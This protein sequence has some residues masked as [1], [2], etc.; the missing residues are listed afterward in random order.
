MPFVTDNIKIRNSDDQYMDLNPSSIDLE[1]IKSDIN[2]IK[3]SIG[4]A[5][6][7]LEKLLTTG[8]D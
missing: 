3:E 4:Q 8:V 5:N 6:S 2:E 7:I 1:E